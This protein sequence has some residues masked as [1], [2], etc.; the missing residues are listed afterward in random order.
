MRSDHFD[1]NKNW[2]T[3]RMKEE[4]KLNYEDFCT[5]FFFPVSYLS[6]CD[7]KNEIMSFDGSEC[8]S[9]HRCFSEL[10]VR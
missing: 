6:W 2:A 8:R 5:H 9:S 10:A 1:R 7:D 4:L 3:M